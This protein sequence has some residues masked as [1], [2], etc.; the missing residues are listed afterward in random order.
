MHGFNDAGLQKARLQRKHNL[1][2]ATIP[3]RG[4]DKAVRQKENRFL[5]LDVNVNLARKHLHE[6]VHR[7]L[8]EMVGQRQ[9]I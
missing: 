4:H 8:C 6:G 9:S 1:Q 3:D 7:T 2:L 5:R